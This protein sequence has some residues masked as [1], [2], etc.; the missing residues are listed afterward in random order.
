MLAC[1]VASMIV[2][3]VIDVVGYKPVAVSR[4][5]SFRGAVHAGHRPQQQLCRGARFLRVAGL[6]RHRLEHGRQHAVAVGPF[7]RQESRGRLNLGNVCFGL[8]V[9]LTPLIVSFLFQKLATKTPSRW[10]RSSCWCRSRWRMLATYP[11]SEGDSR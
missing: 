8:G 5:S 6:W 10:W 9:L 11:P 3:I 4:A 7:R 1:L 2:G